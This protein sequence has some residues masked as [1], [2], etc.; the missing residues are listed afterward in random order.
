MKQAAKLIDVANDVQ[1][2]VE[3]DDNGRVVGALRSS[4]GTGKAE[5]RSAARDRPPP[6]SAA[7]RLDDRLGREAWT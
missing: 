6:R 3:E 2:Q 4:V 7:D 5:L 1:R